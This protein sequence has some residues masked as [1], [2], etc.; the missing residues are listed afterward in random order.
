MEGWGHPLAVVA[1]NEGAGVG[2]DPISPRDLLRVITKTAD[3]TPRQFRRKGVIGPDT[4]LIPEAM[5][6]KSR[7]KAGKEAEYEIAQYFLN[8][9]DEYYDKTGKGT[10]YANRAEDPQAPD[11]SWDKTAIDTTQA[12]PLTVIPTSTINPPRPR[13]TAAGYDK[14]RKVLTV[15]FRDGT[16]YNYYDVTPFMW[17]NFTRAISKGRFIKKNLDGHRRGVAS[18]FGIPQEHRQAIYRAARTAQWRSEGRQ[19]KH[20]KDSRRRKAHKAR[21]TISKT[22]SRTY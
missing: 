21:A 5:I 11:V 7:S 12:A 10:R 8:Q 6:V 1:Q 18:L 13:S 19:S 17:M 15:V 2:P 4:T 20:T 3:A 22:R 16:F 9:S 14:Q